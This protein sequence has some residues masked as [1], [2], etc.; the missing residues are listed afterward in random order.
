[1]LSK[2]FL[3]KIK[4]RLVNERKELLAKTQTDLDI[5]SVDLDGD[6]TD[7]IQGSMLIEMQNKI[8]IR[9][10]EKISCIDSA[11][12]RIEDSTYGICEDCEE[13]IPEKRLDANPYFLTCV[14]CAE[15]RELEEKQKR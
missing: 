2:V 4:E 5:E 7:E 1:M 3:R 6:E 9:N 10:T 13:Y 11:L 14:S 12:D 15:D 8:S